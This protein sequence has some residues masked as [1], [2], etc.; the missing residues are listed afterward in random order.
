MYL[1]KREFRNIHFDRL[2]TSQ[3]NRKAVKQLF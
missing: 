2:K 1:S 3:P